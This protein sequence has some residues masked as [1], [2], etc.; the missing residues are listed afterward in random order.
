MRWPVEIIFQKF[1][2]KT[3][4]KNYRPDIDG[5]RALAVVPV[6]LFHAKFGCPGGFVGVDVFFV[7]SGFL[8]STLILKELADGDFSLIAF[9]ERRIRRILP[10]LAVMVLATLVAGWFLFVPE[11]FKKLGQSVFAQTLLLSNFFFY[12]QGFWVGGYFSATAEAQP[13]LHTWSLAVEEQFYLFF[14]LLLIFLKHCSRPA[15]TIIISALA[16]VSLGLSWY[17]CHAF[18]SATFYFLPTR[19]WELFLGTLLALMR[20]QLTVSAPMRETTGWIGVILIAYAIFFYDANTSFPGLGAIPPCLG[21]ALVIFSGESK[22]SLVGQML[23]FKPVAFIGLISYSLYLWHWPLL[24]FSKYPFN[25]EGWKIRA[26]M[27][28]ASLAL[29]ILSWRFIET[30]FRKRRIW[31][32]RLQIFGFAGFSAAALLVFGFFVDKSQGVPLR[33][34]GKNLSYVITRS[35]I[36]FRNS[37]KLDEAVAGKFVEFGSPDTNRPIKLLIWGDSHGM[38]I[39]SVLNELCLRYAWRGIEATHHSTAPIL[40]FISRGQYALNDD[41]PT[42]A[43]AITNFIAQRH[44]KNVI[45]CAKWNGYVKTEEF[46][47]DLLQTV[48]TLLDM[49]TSVY[50][51]KDVP[52]HDTDLPAITALAALHDASLEPL[53]ITPEKHAQANRYLAATFGQISQMGATV[54][55]PAD[56]FLNSQGL[57]D[58]VKNDQILYWDGNHLT[59]EGAALLTPLFEPIF[60]NENRGVQGRVSI[61]PP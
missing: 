54:L 29:A 8:I 6:V 30:P 11:D 24:V 7:I 9:W 35:H 5:L 55:D 13:L 28:V 14:P 33:F 16:M 20:G 43:Q 15:L 58:V 42:F 44:I 50:V 61:S 32:K 18:P 1:V 4:S 36:A 38:A 41:S 46:K 17:G 34:S 37:V 45:I 53:M 10:A 49:G 25:Y 21:A 51:L 22:L 2:S 19:A 27:L 26:A 48:R 57:Y 47:N 39:T 56:Y 31:Q 23:A 40:G 3:H 12:Q 52:E 60:K 59:V